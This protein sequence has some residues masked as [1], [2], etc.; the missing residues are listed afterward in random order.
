MGVGELLEREQ[1]VPV[2]KITNQGAREPAQ[3]ARAGTLAG[4]VQSR[5]VHEHRIVHAQGARRC[6]HLG[7]EFF[8]APG[9]VFREGEGGV[10]GRGH[11]HALEQVLRERP[12][13][14]LE[15]HARA[16]RRPCPGA[17]L[18]PVVEL[19]RSGLQLLE[20]QIRRHQ[21]DEAR[22]RDARV[23]PVLGQHQPAAVIHEQ[24]GRGAHVRRRRSGEHARGREES[25][26]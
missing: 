2:G 8:L 6:V 7:D 18:D 25:E 15:K 12:R 11:D 3:I 21:L 5:D 22:R 19:E 26:Y 13:P 1:F 20:Q 9:H 16:L 17:D 24:P 14:G 10:V 23:G 4:L